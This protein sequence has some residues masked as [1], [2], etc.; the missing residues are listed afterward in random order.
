MKH[1][2][3]PEVLDGTGE[4]ATAEFEAALET[5]TAGRTAR[6]MIGNRLLLLETEGDVRRAFPGLGRPVRKGRRG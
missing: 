3:S 6:V 5:V 1:K 4:L 2:H